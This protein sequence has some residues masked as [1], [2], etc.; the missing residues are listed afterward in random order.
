MDLHKELLVCKELAV[1]AG[2]EILKVYEKDFEVKYKSDNSPVTEADKNANKLI[3]KGLQESFPEYAIL[4]EESTDDKSRLNND[5]CFIID[6][7]DGSREFVKRSDE[8]TVN[9]ALSYKNKS[10]LGVIY[11]PVS[12]QLY[13][14]YKGYGAYYEHDGTWEKIKVS[15]RT[16][17][18]R[19]VMSKYP[20]KRLLKIIDENNIKNTISI[21]SSWK[22]CLIAAG[23]AEVYYRFGNTM[24]WDTAAMQC[25]VEEAGGIFK[26]LDSTE[27]FYNRVNTVNDK[28]FY[29]L[30]RIENLFV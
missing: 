8:F 26:Q 6:P 1:I 30:N 18:V 16:E 17:D 3:I 10:V 29:I 13:Y 28:G 24:E 27:M 12:R 4:S 22:G 21:G 9:I 25:I 7:L 11:V 2:Y 23:Q 19:M 14:A 15:D 20:F 5:Y